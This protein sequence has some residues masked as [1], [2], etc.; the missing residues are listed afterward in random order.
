MPFSSRILGP[1]TSKQKQEVRAAGQRPDPES[2]TGMRVGGRVGMKRGPEL[3]PS[4]DLH[5]RLFTEP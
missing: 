4:P 5:W 2:W 1:L 3:H